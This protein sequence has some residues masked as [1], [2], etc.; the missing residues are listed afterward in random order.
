MEN[1]GKY[2]RFSKMDIYKCPKSKIPKNFYV[3]KRVFFDLG[4]NI[5][6]PTPII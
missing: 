1:T 5:L 6:T 4:W 3:K 2:S